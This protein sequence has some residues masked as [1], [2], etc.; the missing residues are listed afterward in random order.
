MS[1][2]EQ[3]VIMPQTWAA[4]KSE[5]PGPGNASLR[6]EIYATARRSGSVICL[7][8]RIA[9]TACGR[10]SLE[11]VDAMARREYAERG[12]SRVYV[13]E[14]DPDRYGTSEVVAYLDQPH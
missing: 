4:I 10:A 12:Y 2:N 6:E 11:E 8:R 1:A 13:G 9:L 14:G 3:V 7:A 5:F